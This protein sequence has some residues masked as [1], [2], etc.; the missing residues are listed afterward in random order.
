MKNIDKSNKNKKDGIVIYQAKNGAIEL[1]GDFENETIWATQSQIAQLFNI[2]QSVVSRHINN[3]LKDGEID[4]K[5]NMQKMHIA[6]SDKL[7]FLYSLDVVLGVGY[8]TNSRVAIGFR[9]WATQ[10]LREHIT[11]GY[12]INR[13]QISKNYDAFMK[14]VSD[15]VLYC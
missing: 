1:S 2:D 8:K 11:K 15:F 6:N 7:V 5:S 3:L 9:K 14:S 10:T 4:Q 13:K 12:T